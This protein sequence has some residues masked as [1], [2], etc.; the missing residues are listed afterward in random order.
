MPRDSPD[1]K[2]RYSIAEDAGE[3]VAAFH[4]LGPEGGNEM[5]SGKGYI[6]VTLTLPRE[7]KNWRPDPFPGSDEAFKLGCSCPA[8][9]P[10]PGALIFA[11]NCPVHELTR[12]LDS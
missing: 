9:Q 2:C 3:A 4:W 5:E 12:K 8:N 1:D 11:A 7:D 10:W 6:K